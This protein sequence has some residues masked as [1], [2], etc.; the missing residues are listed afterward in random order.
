MKVQRN[1]TIKVKELKHPE[2][3][4]RKHPEKQ[5]EEFVRSLEKFGQIR[6]FVIDEEN[7]V[8]C[9][10]GMLEAML[11]M[12]IDTAIADIYSGMTESDKKKLMLADNKISDLGIDD[13][14]AMEELFGSVDDFDIPG[15]DEAVL[16]ALYGDVDE[17]ALDD[18]GE[19]TFEQ[20]QEFEK[21]S[22]RK[23]EAMNGEMEEPEDDPADDEEDGRT[24]TCPHCGGAF[25]V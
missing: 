3:N 12:S 21:A 14:F 17:D 22:E 10:N 18:Y 25:H 7:V 9:G 2:V 1:K 16:D 23:E 5:I 24:V 8:W 4:A 6:P 11:R 19:V 20:R 13:K 15:F